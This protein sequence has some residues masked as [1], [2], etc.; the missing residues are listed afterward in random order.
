MRGF[1][2]YWH[3][4]IL[5]WVSQLNSFFHSLSLWVQ[6]WVLT[7][8]NMTCFNFQPIF[9]KGSPKMVETNAKKQMLW[10]LL[11]CFGNH[12]GD[13]W[14]NINVYSLNY[15][16][17]ISTHIQV[18]IYLTIIKRAVYFSWFFFFSTWFLP[19]K[20]SSIDHVSKRDGSTREEVT[21][22]IF[23]FP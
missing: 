15:Y 8:N 10:S 18:I 9:S 17:H 23:S 6:L 5:A 13:R 12:L 14:L 1:I 19:G 4:C 16:C 2:W 21:I 11:S 22:N 7:T 20:T 3:E